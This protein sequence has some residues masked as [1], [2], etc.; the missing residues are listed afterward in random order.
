ML[1]VLGQGAR[2]PYKNTYRQLW[3]VQCDCGK[4]VEM[5]RGFFEHNGRVSCGCKRK[6]GLVDNLRRPLDIA[7]QRFDSLLCVH[8]TGKKDTSQKPTWLLQCDCGNFRELSLSRIRILERECTRINCGDRTLHPDKYLVYPPIPNPYPTEAG[9][10]LTKYLPKTKLGYR[11]IDSAVE[12]ERRD[13]LIRAA[14]IITYR[15]SRGEEISEL[16]ESRII[17]KHLRYCSIDVFW[18]RKLES[19]GGLL[20][21]VDWKKRELGSAMTAITSENYPVIE[22]QGT[23]ILPTKKLK[24]RRC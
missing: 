2:Q 23:K 11:Q 3:R 12:D 20:F 13:R 7:G 10:L 15:R 18:R 22:T 9:K 19:Q 1:V 5:P 16:H 21:D 17:R 24:F 8:L 14:W 4:T 6:R